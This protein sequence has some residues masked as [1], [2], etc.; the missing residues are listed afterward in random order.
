[1]TQV[2]KP[3]EFTRKAHASACCDP[4]FD[5][6]NRKDFEAASRGLIHRPGDPHISANDGSIAWHHEK[7]ESFLHGEAPE[8][9]HPS[10][11]RHALL[12]NYRGLFKVTDGV[13]QV[14]G[15]SLANVTF[16]ESDNGYIVIDPLTTVEVAAYALKLLYEH[17]GE[18]PIVAM[19]YSHTHSDHFGGVKG[20][21]TNADVNSGKVRV[22]A[23]AG[24]VEWVLKEQG[25]AAEGMPSRNAYMYG[26][27]LPVSSTG[28]VDTGLGQAIEGGEITF[29]EPTDI[30]GTAGGEMTIDGVQIEFMYAPGEAPTGMHCYLPRYKALHVADNCYMCLHNVYTIRG[31]FPRDALQWADSVARSQQ[32]RDTEFLVSGHNWPVFG[33]SDVQQFLAEQSAGI[34]YMHDQ[35]IRLMSQGYVPAEIA[36][37]IEFP[38]TLAR[39]WHLRGYYGTLKHNVRGIY[40]YYLGWYDGN[41]A[42]LDE[43]PP[44]EKAQRTIDYM[45]GTEAVLARVQED[46]ANGDYRWVVHILDQVLWVEP[47]NH[48]AREMAAAAHMQ[49]G[50]GAENATWRNA[51]LSAAQELRDGLPEPK[52]ARVL[53]DVMRGMEAL[54]LLNA[55]SI[56]LNGPRAV[57]QH[58]TINWMVTDTSEQCHTQLEHCVLI[59]RAGFADN[60]DATVQLD[61][62]LLSRFALAELDADSLRAHGAIIS[63]NADIVAILHGLLDEFP[64]WFPISTHDLKLGEQTANS[65][66]QQPAPQ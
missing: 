15:E 35:T 48:A 28:I 10:L 55:L 24:F 5:W 41:P 54:L 43:L 53:R 1:M 30:I 12:N 6:A 2:D 4:I 64:A 60:A 32:F 23:S 56:R 59:R 47:H 22:I 52:N 49:L 33:Q 11:W 37:A 17:V 19:I 46:F 21:I 13:Y 26:E 16:V 51:Y 44:R 31:A 62:A 63:G 40:A 39:L 65:I 18:K 45:G 34:Q 50:Y 38:P 36:D 9:V 57:G 29:I 66:H 20:M 7:F 3:S 42:N 27:N 8:T 58:F 25:I 14:R 61:H